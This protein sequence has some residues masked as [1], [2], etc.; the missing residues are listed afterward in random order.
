MRGVKRAF[1]YR[2]GDAREYALI[3]DLHTKSHN[4]EYRNSIA[5]IRCLNNLPH[6]HIL[7]RRKPALCAPILDLGLL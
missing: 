7:L 4:L 5:K 1:M 3:L 2:L 6:A